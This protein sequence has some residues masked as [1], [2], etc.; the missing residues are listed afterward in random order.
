MKEF[1]AARGFLKICGI[2]V[3]NPKDTFNAIDKNKG[4]YILFDEFADWAIKQQ[5]D[6]PDD[7]N[8]NCVRP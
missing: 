6:L 3:V 2:D 5:L 7:D 1:I 4:G 8:F